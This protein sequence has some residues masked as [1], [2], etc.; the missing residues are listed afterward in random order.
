MVKRRSFVLLVVMTAVW[1]LLVSRLWWLQW[2]TSRDFSG[3]KI[4]LVSQAVA[5]R[6]Q[7]FVI[8]SGRGHILDRKGIPLTGGK[9]L[10]LVLFPLA[11]PVLADTQKRSMLAQ[12]ANVPEELLVHAI[13]H[14]KRPIALQDGKGRLYELTPKQAEAVRKLSIPGIEALPVMER[15]PRNGTARQVIG[16]LHQN[17][18]LVQDEYAEELQNGTMTLDTPVGASGLERSFDRLLRG[19]KPV[20]F[21]YVVDGEGRWLKGLGVRLQQDNNPFFPL[22]VVTTLSRDLQEEMEKV[23]DRAGIGTGSIVVLDVRSGDVL[24]MV[25]RPAYDPDLSEP[26][27]M[28]RINRAV[29]QLPPGSVFKTVVAAA[30]LGEGLV[31]PTDRFACTGEYGKYGFSCWKKDGHGVLTMDEAFAHSCNIAFAQI[32]LRVGGD[33]IETYARR[34]GIGA[35]VGW[36]EP[37]LFGRH[38]FRQIYGEEPGGV[39]ASQDAKKDEGALIQT[40]IGQRDVRMTPLQAASLMA[41]VARGGKPVQSRL[42]TKIVYQ[43]GV[44]YYRFAPHVLSEGISTGTALHLQDMLRKV[45]E[46]G[47]G[48]MLASLPWRVA[49]KSGTAQV[50]VNG[51]ERYHHWFAGYVPADQPRYAIAVTAENQLPGVPHL[52]TKT[53][54]MIVETMAALSVERSETAQ[55]NRSK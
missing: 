46:E 30:A 13:P 34:L 15:H 29:L 20:R 43:N 48:H 38:V 12:M 5:Q 44:P 6:Q 11:K 25:S 31:R 8:D 37:D 53:F 7:S 49:G 28:A 26:Q 40:A 39:F 19:E 18:K 10:A 47:T 27:E 24:A 35:P 2:G 33:A 4:D 42:V 32:A 21:S 23:A 17:P 50:Q 9:R 52:A 1:M 55:V 3:R 41:A 36:S 16:F 45:V 51:A 14:L 54:G 22:N